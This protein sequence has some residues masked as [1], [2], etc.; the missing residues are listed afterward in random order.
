VSAR[1]Q[2]FRRGLAWKLLLGVALVV[3]ALLVWKLTPLAE[4]AKPERIA[5]WLDTVEQYRWAPLIMIGAYLAGGLVMF[6]VTV[7]GAAVAIT[8]PPWK[9]AP[10]ALIGILLSAGL[11]HWLGARF[12][13]DRTSERLGR[14]REKLEEILTDQGIVTLAALRMVPIAPFTLVNLAAGVMGVRF[15]DFLV[16]TALGVAPSITL[17]SLFGRQVRAFWR[18]PSGTG[19]ALIVAVAIAWIGLAFALQRF[20]AYVRH[21]GGGAKHAPAHRDPPARAA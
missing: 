12:L 6:P 18:D 2:L 15:R 14:I 16:G 5:K 10:V 21:R 7:L 20:V 1:V 8:F 17:L 11:H 4:L 9:A 3:G 13:K 19:V